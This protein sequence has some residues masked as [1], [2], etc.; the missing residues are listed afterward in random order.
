MHNLESDNISVRIQ[1]KF[2]ENSSLENR[3][4]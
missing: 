1:T 4:A 3:W 2:S